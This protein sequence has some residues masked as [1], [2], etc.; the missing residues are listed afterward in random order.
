M[1][2]YSTFASVFF[3]LSFTPLPIFYFLC[4][5]VS[6]DFITNMKWWEWPLFVPQLNNPMTS[7]VALLETEEEVPLFLYSTFDHS[8]QGRRSFPAPGNPTIFNYRG[9]ILILE[10]AHKVMVI[11]A[12]CSVT[13]SWWHVHITTKR[14]AASKLSVSGASLLVLCSH[15]ILCEKQNQFNFGQEIKNIHWDLE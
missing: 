7:K 2:W 13:S 3:F 1:R 12:F 11:M 6:L 5:I 15:W 14:S 4:V 8:L 10:F 9:F